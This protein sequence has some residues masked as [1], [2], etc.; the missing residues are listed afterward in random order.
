MLATESELR[1]LVDNWKL[2]Y[3]RA[4]T[5]SYNVTDFYVMPE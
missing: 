1:A 4:I 5:L 2:L 3:N